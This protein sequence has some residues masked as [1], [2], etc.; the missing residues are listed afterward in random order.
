MMMQK[1]KLTA[2]LPPMSDLTRAMAAPNLSVIRNALVQSEIPIPIVYIRC[3][4]VHQNMVQR[5][6][7]RKSTYKV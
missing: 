3:L 6:C 5:D 2:M 4:S 1:T 7:G